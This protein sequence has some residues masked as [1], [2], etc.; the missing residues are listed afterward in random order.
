MVYHYPDPDVML[1][2]IRAK[3]RE[4][5]LPKRIDV[6][7]LFDRAQDGY[8]TGRIAGKRFFSLLERVGGLVLDEEEKAF[9]IR[10]FGDH[11]QI[12]NYAK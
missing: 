5:L 3:A 9:V 4:T 6:R 12:I 1:S 10:R 7:K 8:A 11:R 2:G